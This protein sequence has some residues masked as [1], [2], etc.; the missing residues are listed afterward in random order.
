MKFGKTAEEKQAEELAERQRAEAAAAEQAARAHAASPVGRAEAALQ[1]GD[2]FFQIPLPVSSLSGQPSW[3]G[4]TD[5]QVAPV[6]PGGADVLGQIE[7]V[8]WR[9]EHVG[10]VFIETGATSSNRMF[11]SGEGTVT[12]G[13]VTGIYLFR[14]AGR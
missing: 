8:G 10:Y 9:L 7:D 5:N 13:V 2:R 14:A 3:F 12:E 11:V 4:S 6:G 1:R